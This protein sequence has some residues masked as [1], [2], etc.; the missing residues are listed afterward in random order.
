MHMNNV[1]VCEIAYI[2]AHLFSFYCGVASTALAVLSQNDLC[3]IYVE[4]VNFFDSFIL[5]YTIFIFIWT[6]GRVYFLLTMLLKILMGLVCV[7]DS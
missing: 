5:Y 3:M 6:N 1:C 4:M 2:Y 7:A